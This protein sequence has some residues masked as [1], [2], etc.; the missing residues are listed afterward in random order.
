LLCGEVDFV[1]QGA[2]EFEGVESD[3]HD[4]VSRCRLGI[5]LMASGRE[6]GSG[7]I[8]FSS[9]SHS[10]CNSHVTPTREQSGQT[11]S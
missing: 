10:S 9:V 2:G 6:A 8:R 4:F 3:A 1:A 5:R 11:Q 7:R